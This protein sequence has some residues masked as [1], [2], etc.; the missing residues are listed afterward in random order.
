MGIL[1]LVST[2]PTLPIATVCISLNTCLHAAAALLIELL[3]LMHVSSL[4]LCS[5]GGVYVAQLG[6]KSLTTMNAVEITQYTRYLS[7]LAMACIAFRVLWVIDIMS[8][9]QHKT[10]EARDS[11]NTTD[12]SSDPNS[13]TTDD[14]QG[15]RRNPNYMLNVGIQVGSSS[16]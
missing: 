13:N 4:Q 15:V 14:G 12:P 3:V 1:D 6:L 16:R 2:L 8:V 5:M 11:T 10:N 7:M 9:E